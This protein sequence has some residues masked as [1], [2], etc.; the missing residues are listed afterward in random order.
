MDPTDDPIPHTQTQR[1]HQWLV[2]HPISAALLFS[3]GYVMLG[4]VYV[5]VSGQWAAMTATSTGDLAWLESVKGTLFIVATGFM[6]FLFAGWLLRHVQRREI[7]IQQHRDALIA[8]ERRAAAGV[9][10]ASIAHDT[11]N[12][13]QIMEY[14]LAMLEM[15]GLPEEKRQQQITRLRS[16]TEQL[17][18]LSGRMS[19]IGGRNLGEEARSMDIAAVVEGAVQL[20]RSHHKVRECVIELILP[21]NAPFYGNPVLVHHAVLNLILNAADATGNGGRI[22]VQLEARGEGFVLSVHDNGPGVPENLRNQIFAPFYTTKADGTGLGLLTIRACAVTHKGQ[23][24]VSTSPLG[25]ACFEMTL[26]RLEERTGTPAPVTAGQA[27][28]SAG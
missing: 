28:R 26:A 16:A 3:I 8:A 25:G 20:A 24:N 21:Q 11:N 13:L 6:L 1:I 4:L 27:V 18:E 7:L 5:Y 19:K 10:A 12:V 2:T 23:I 14:A 17:R 22:R 9:F 15:A